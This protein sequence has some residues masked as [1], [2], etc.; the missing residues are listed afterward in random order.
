MLALALVLD[1]VIGEPAPL[2]K[3]V[4]HPIVLMGRLVDML[5]EGL[6]T[7]RFRY[8]RGVAAVII[9][10][11]ATG[12]PALLLSIDL[13]A[14]I[15]EL[16][17]AAV[18]L[19]H[20]S[21]VDHVTAVADGLSK[22][23]E[24]GRAAVAHIV[25]RDTQV[26]DEAGVARAAIESGAENF[27]DGVVAPAFWFLLLGLPGIVIYKAVNTADSMIGHRTER[28]GRFGWAAARLDDGLNFVP[29]RLTAGLIALAGALA[30]SGGVEALRVAAR[31][32][33]L[34]RSINA[35]W[36]EAA[37]A[38]T[39]GV[40]L[41]GPRHYG[42]ALTDDPFMNPAGRKTLGAKDIRASVTVLWRAWGLLLAVVAVLWVLAFAVRYLFA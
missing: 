25:G 10:V 9:L 12:A 29:A 6:N 41:A 34:H 21:L 11:L 4:P 36:P 20:R 28:H 31:D 33:W 7:G 5:D 26:L 17:L 3:R 35:G 15:V 39:L 27:S 24:E 14:G 30:G 40:A 19:A 1:A 8:L 22:G 23:L 16:L 18:L 38:A 2:W 13:F 42:G 37:M 32:G